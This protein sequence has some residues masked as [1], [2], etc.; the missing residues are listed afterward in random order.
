MVDELV[1]GWVDELLR[2]SGVSNPNFIVPWGA[3][4]PPEKGRNGENQ[5]NYVNKKALEEISGLKQGS[6]FASVMS[7]STYKT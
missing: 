7:G 2:E 5:E 6:L 4:V 1:T 3:E